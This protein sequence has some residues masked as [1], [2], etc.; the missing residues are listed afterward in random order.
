MFWWILI[1]KSPSQTHQKSP[2][3]QDN[4]K[5]KVSSLSWSQHLHAML[6]FFSGN[7]DRKNDLRQRL[8]LSSFFMCE[9]W[10]FP[11]RDQQICLSHVN[12]RKAWRRDVAIGSGRSLALSDATWIYSSRLSMVRVGRR[13]RSGCFFRRWEWASSVVLENSM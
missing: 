7:K 6:N 4:G 11:W 8:F 12:T 10:R 1:D 3:N 9:S 13:L 5:R 2:S